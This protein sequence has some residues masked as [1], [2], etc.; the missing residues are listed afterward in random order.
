MV[1]YI[2]PVILLAGNVA[3]SIETD[4]K[5]INRLF[6]VLISMG[7]G[8]GV[9]SAAPAAD[10]ATDPGQIVFSSLRPGNW[11]IFYFAQ[12]GTSPKRLTDHPGLDYEAVFSPDGR[13]VVFTSERHGHPD[14]YIIDLENNTEPRLLIDNNAMEDQAVISPDGRTIAFVST[15]SGNADIYS[16][17]FEPEKTRGMDKAVNLTRH[18]GGDFRP[19]FSPDGRRIAFS[20]DRDTEVYGHPGLSFMRQREGEIYVMD[21]DGTNTKRLTDVRSWDGS[22]E[23]SGDGKSIYFYSGR[24][25]ELPGPPKSHILGQEGGFRIWA[26]DS[27][28]SHQRAVTPVGVE[29]LAPALT[30]DGRIAYQTRRSFIGWYLQSTR[31]DGTDPRLESDEAGEYWNPDYHHTS[32]AMVCHGVGPLTTDKVA[33]Q[34]ILGP[35][36]ILATDYPAEIEFLDKTVTLYAMRHTSG[37]AAHPYQRKLAVTIEINA[38]TRFVVEDY[39]GE[40]QNELFA[41]NGIGIV[42]GTLN[43]IFGLKWSHDADW[44]T[45]TQGWFFGDQTKKADVWKIRSDGSGRVNLT[46]GSDTNNGMSAFSPDAKS[47][48]FRSARTGNFDLYLM[49]ADGSNLIQLTNDEAK[50]NFPVFAPSGDAV[51]FS[52]DRDSK[53][54]PLGFKSFDNYIMKLNPDGTP[55]ELVRITDDPGHDAHPN[56]SPDGKWIVYTSER[57]GLSDEEPLVQEVVFGPQMYGEIF[58]YRLSDGLHIRL[59]HNKWEESGPFWMQMARQTATTGVD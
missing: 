11:D 14:L 8:T 42:S 56:F 18:P 48:V 16:M 35:G 31:L 5:I 39:D 49:D 50:D 6:A 33:V 52:S 40:N 23:W 19:A 20:T 15:E 46:A 17:P 7:L 22:P 44:I 38:G 29:A 12:P 57:A 34:D 30:H 13:W 47:I 43:R 58:A 21:A 9:F 27:D 10:M 54:D 32:G 28:G 3:G 41:V 24:P 55:G 45:Y 1:L 53:P 36:G 51:V 26:M 4:M 2:Q 59:T 25:R 37:L